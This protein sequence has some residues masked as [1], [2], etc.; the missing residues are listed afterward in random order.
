VDSHIKISSF[1]GDT[2]VMGSLRK[3][4]RLKIRG[5]DQRD[6]PYL[7][8]GGEDL[9]LDQRVQQLF[10]VM[11]E[12]FASDA[13]CSRRHLTLRTYQVIPMTGQVGMIE[14]IDNTKPLKGLI[15]DE[16]SRESGKGEQISRIPAANRRTK[17][18][19]SFSKRAGLADKYADM[20]DKA[21]RDACVK[22]MAAEAETITWDLLRRAV[23][24]LCT[25]PEACHTIRSHFA[26]SLAAFNICSYII[27]IGDRHLDN[28]LLNYQDGTV[29]GIDFGHAFGSATQVLPIPELVPFRLTRQFV[30]FMRPLQAE[31][32]LNHSMTHCLRA[33]QENK[34]VLLSTMDVFVTEPLLDWEK[35]AQRLVSQQGGKKDSAWFPKRKIEIA[36]KKLEGGNPA[37]IICLELEE[38]VHKKAACL[39]SLLKIVLGD[40]KHNP[41][42]SVGEQCDTVAEQV[43]CLVDLAT[44][45]NVL[46]RMYSGWASW[47]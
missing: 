44:D 40:P 45:P 41:R 30:N 16:L 2:L 46:C 15:E 20:Y 13:Q 39:P 36:T 33:L 6:Y 7:V 17:W 5:N 22:E 43:D 10:S 27:G 31:G 12:I 26:K 35:L 37:H 14:W 28:F 18:L 23:F 9:R 8:K 21:S 1:D 47:I 11:N 38:S 34:D 4:K 32:M 42:A 29:I 19:G 25:T 24:A 3:P